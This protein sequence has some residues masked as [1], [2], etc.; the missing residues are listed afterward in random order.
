MKQI[1]GLTLLACATLPHV[2]CNTPGRMRAE[3]ASVI[4][5]SRAYPLLA[6]I[7]VP[8][9]FRAIY[10]RS[11]GVENARLRMGKYAFTGWG[12]PEKVFQF[13]HENMGQAGFTLRQ[14]SLDAGA[15][16]MIFDSNQEEARVLIRKAGLGT[17]LTIELIPK[18]MPGQPPIAT[19]PAGQSYGPPVAQQRRMPPQGGR[20]PMPRR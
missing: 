8:K 18:V 3:P 6:G 16:L 15:Y 1:A 12:K 13:Y 11:T 10:E 5:A 14:R 19:P 9:G 7:P 4:T 2:G 20:R 17:D